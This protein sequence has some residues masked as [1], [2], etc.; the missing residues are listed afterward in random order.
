[1]RINNKNED[2]RIDLPKDTT[3]L[4]LEG[5]VL[6]CLKKIPDN[7]ISVVVTS[8]PYW[9][10]R[11]Y[12]VEG[13]IGQ[14]KT[15]E[16]YIKKM[17][18]VGNE[19]KRVLR[20]DGC[21][22]LNI[23]DSYYNGNLQMIP[24]RVAYEM[25]TNGWRLRNFI[26]WYKPN[27]MPSPIQNRFATTWEPI[28]FFIKNETYKKYY[29]NLDEIR[30]KHKTKEEKGSN[31]P[32]TL[33]IEEFN[34]LKD[35][36]NLKVEPSN[37]KNYEGKFKDTKRINLGASPGARSVVCGEYYSLQRKHKIDDD[38]KFEI[39]VYLRDKRVEKGIS[40]KEIDEHFRYKDTAGHWFRTDYSGSSLPK[41]DDWVKLKELLDLDE[42]YDKI[43][44]E[45]HYVLQTVRPHPNGKNPG[46]MWKMKTAKLKD[47]H[48][49]VFPEELPQR[50]IKACCPKDGI[51]LD[52][53]AGSGTTGKVARELGRKSILIEIN[54]GYIK[55]IK[56]RCKLNTKPLTSWS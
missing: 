13:Q 42:R 12:E 56:E 52:P 20:D 19:I 39:I 38:L 22:F 45:Q 41:P 33:S 11:D 9:N 51:V 14:E 1:M 48:F 31:L 28:F 55:I 47:A 23:G 32:E 44:T 27:H 40:T 36:L 8:P 17:V 30:V 43:M 53:F 3:P 5:D 21:Y 46:D 6:E 16:E 54:P 7:S 4:I 34:K 24:S 37:G 50:V 15:I 18:D 26:V 2:S 29:F 25:Q 49:A 10:L 35:K